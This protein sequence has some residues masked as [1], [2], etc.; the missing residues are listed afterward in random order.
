M[1]AG[2]RTLVI[3]LLRLMEVENNVAQLELFQDDFEKLMMVL[4]DIGFL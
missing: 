2:L 1:M 3:E 4:N